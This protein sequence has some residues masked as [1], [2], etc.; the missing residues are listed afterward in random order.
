MPSENVHQ[1][2]AINGYINEQPE[3]KRLDMQTLHDLILNTNPSCQLWFTD[4]R[5]GEGKVVSNPNIGYGQ[6]NIKYADGTSRPFYQIGLSANKTGISIYILGKTDKTYLSE[7][8]G[9]KLGKV[10]VTGYCIKFKTLQDIHLTV[11]ESIIQ[12]GFET[13]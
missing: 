8:F 12:Y 4:G 6:C 1:T 2:A 5:N 10:S 11:L 9:K 3:A 7:T 13:E